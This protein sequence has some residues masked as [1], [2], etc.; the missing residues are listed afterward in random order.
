MTPFD[1]LP[2][3]SGFLIIQADNGTLILIV[4]HPL[5]DGA[6]L[7]N[8]QN[9]VHVRHLRGNL[10]RKAD[11]THGLHALCRHLFFLAEPL[12]QDPQRLRNMPLQQ[13]FP[14]KRDHLLPVIQVQIPRSLFVGDQ[15]G[16][17]KCRLPVIQRIPMHEVEQDGLRKRPSCGIL[18]YG[19][20]IILIQLGNL[21]FSVH[22]PLIPHKIALLRL[23]SLDQ[24]RTD[25]IQYHRL[26]VHLVDAFQYPEHGIA[27]VLLLAGKIGNIQRQ[28]LRHQTIFRSKIQNLYFKSAQFF[29]K[30]RLFL[31]AHIG[32]QIKQD[33]MDAILELLF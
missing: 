20:H 25:R 14:G 11:I 33:L 22:R 23:V 29:K 1:R 32:F 5:A 4:R 28:F 24:Q 16:V 30:R 26:A 12:V 7:F 15:I 3:N 17:Q 19:H 2:Y 6:I 13:L 10:V 8:H 31:I 9:A 27:V 18:V 21:K